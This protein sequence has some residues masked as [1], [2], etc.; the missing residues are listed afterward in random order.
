M[1]KLL[2]FVLVFGF[3]ILTMGQSITNYTFSS[4]S[5]TFTALSGGTNPTNTGGLD[6]GYFNNIP[7]GFNFIYMGVPYSV[8]SS[9]TDGTLV[10]AGTTTSMTTNNLTSGIPRPMLAPLWDDEALTALTD[11]TYQ[12]SGSIGSRVFTAEWLNVK[13][14]YSATSGCMSFQVKLYEADGKVEFIYHQIG[15]TLVSASASIGI[16]GVATGSGN[17]LSLSSS[18]A[19]PTVSSTTEV[20]TIAAKPAEG[21]VYTFM[22]PAAPANPTTLTFSSVGVGGMTVNWVDN[23]TTES[24]FLITRATDAGFTTN[25]VTSNVASTT[26]AGTG[27]AYNSAVTGLDA[28][29]TYYFKIQAISEG[30]ASVG[31][32]GNQATGSCSFTGGT[33]AVGPSAGAA[34]ATLTAALSA[35]S[36][37]GLLGPVILELQPAYTSASETFPITINAISCLNALNTLTIRPQTGATGL[38]ITS[39]NATA[40]IDF[41]GGDY[42]T[43]DGRPGGSG[44]SELTITNTALGSATA[45]RLIADAT[46]NTIQYCTLRGSAATSQGVITISTGVVTGNDANTISNCNI[47]AA[48]TNYPINGIYSLGSSTSLDNSGITISNNNIYDY[49]SAGSASNG[50]NINSFNSA[51]TIT[52]NKLYQTAS[53]VYTTASTHNGI[54]IA[55]GVGYTISDNVIGYASPGGTGT[56]NMVGLTSGSLGGTFPSAYTT[57]GTANATRFVAINCAFTAAG[58]ASSIQNNTIGGIALYTSSG[59]ATTYGILCGISV[60]SGN[61]NI[62]TITGNAIGATTGTGSL[63][64]ATTT[65]GGVIVGIYSTSSNT[66]TIQNNSIGAID[67]MGTTATICGAITGINSAGTGTFLI[68]GNTIGNATNPNLRMGNLTTGTNL[69]NVGTTF[70]VTSGT[71]TFNGILNGSTGSVT[72]GTLSLPN[73]IRNASQ[74]S[75]STTALFRGIQTTAGTPVISFNTIS[76]ITSAGTSVSFSNGGVG[77]IGIYM[78]VGTTPVIT[79]NTIFNLSLTNTGTGGYNLAGISYTGPATS[80]TISKNKIYGLSNASTSTT[81][82]APGT[83]TGI[84]IRD[85][86]GISTSIDNNMI[87]LGNGQTTNTAFIGIWAQYGLGS[88]TTYKIYHNTI[89]IEGTVV[90]GAQPSMGIQRGDF[91]TTAST[92]QII[93]AKNNFFNN[94]RTGGTGKHY[95]LAN[96]YGV[97]TSSATGWGANA[98]NYNVL[99]SNAA[100][101]GYWSG[102]KTF[103]AWKTASASDVNSLSGITT[104]FVNTAAGDLHMNMGVTPTQIES[105]G[106]VL[107]GYTT[108]FDAQTR[109][110]PSGSVNGGAFAPD[111]GAD[112][113]DGVYLDLVPPLISYTPLS[114]TSSILSRTIT[115]TITDP[116]LVGSGANQPV[117]YWAVN[118]GAYT[119]PVTPTTIVGNQYT[120]TL[121]SGV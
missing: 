62:G 58:T 40:T 52:N 39:S 54:N 32:T 21:Q 103:A 7:I 37:S 84:F 31:L 71:S 47:T 30:A 6:M 2:L 112:E 28:T 119:G 107:A 86:F 34:Y 60:T 88:S 33:Y 100:T 72:I 75:T 55:S 121:G 118:A 45:L 3:N 77:G 15:G 4:S 90:T 19:A 22:P 9:T 93:D 46:N 95:A 109:P 20:I 16:S 116:S 8:C 79:N 57:G 29:T 70:G 17:F 38:V 114:N 48:G 83:A 23:S 1:R 68:S 82:T 80:M 24:G 13:W 10:F 99:N 111:M 102:D 101:I 92:V 97:V 44:T 74:N 18:G 53:R 65:S 87:S 98:S 35:L 69:S 42:I 81:T 49:F 63:Y 41:N 12:T 66:V 110:G 104:T 51:W 120:Y 67:A 94:T 96:N 5:G 27:T 14:N 108:D 117:M 26:T 106:T 91:S 11:F 113:F 50:M 78:Y 61:A 76:N 25:V 56:T 115:I 36:V 105:G 59:A 43:I 64:A 89:N 85:G 73:T